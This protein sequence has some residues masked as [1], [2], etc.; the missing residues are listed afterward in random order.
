[1]SRYLFLL[2]LCLSLQACQQQANPAATISELS[3]DGRIVVINYW[4]IWCAPCRDEIPELNDFA[5]EYS[6]SASVYAVNFDNVKGD[7]LLA[8]AAELG[9]EF[10]LLEHDPASD[11]GY[12]RPTVLPTTLVISSSGKLLKRMFGPQTANTLA[13]ALEGETAQ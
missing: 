11:L 7:E 3:N 13:E 5:R 10:N 9:I 1:M 8:Q 6:N 4:A 2:A 12:P